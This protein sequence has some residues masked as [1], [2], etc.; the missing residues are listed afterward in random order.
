MAGVSV[1][2]LRIVFLI[3]CFFAFSSFTQAHPFSASRLP[4][5]DLSHLVQTTNLAPPINSSNFPRSETCGFEGNPDV[6]GP[7]IRIG[8]YTQTIAVWI[9]KYFLLSQAHVLR[10]SITIFSIALLSV[11]IIFAVR[12]PTVYTVE[13]FIVLQ[14]LSWS[15]LTG[16]R[17]RSSYA[18]QTFRN[19]SV[20]VGLTEMFNMGALILHTWFWFYG[21]DK[22]RM[23][24]CGAFVFFFAKV[25]MYGWFRG[26]MKAMT[27][28]GLLDHVHDVVLRGVGM[29]SDW[30]MRKWEEELEN[31]MKRWE[32]GE[33]E[34]NSINSGA[35]TSDDTFRSPVSPSVQ[36]STKE[37]SFDSSR[38]STWDANSTQADTESI[39]QKIH[40]IQASIVERQLQESLA[41]C[42]PPVTSGRLDTTQQTP[43][44]DSLETQFP[45]F[46]DI[47][48]GE[49]F[50]SHC[51]AARLSPRFQ[52]RHPIVY[53]ILLALLF[54]PRPLSSSDNRTSSTTS[55]TYMPSNSTLPS[56]H[57]PPTPK[58]PISPTAETGSE[59]AQPPTYTTCVIT[60]LQSIFTLNFPHRAAILL[61]HLIRSRSLDP[62]NGVYQLYAAL[63]SS[64]SSPSQST[65]PSPAGIALASSLLLSR[66]PDL[67]QRVKYMQ[68]FIDITIHIFMIL[69]LEFTIVWNGVRGLGG[70]ENVGQLI[71]F[72]IGVGGLGLVLGRWGEY[73][74]GCLRGKR[75]WR[76]MVEE[77]KAERQDDDLVE[78]IGKVYEEW[79]KRIAEEGRSRT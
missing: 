18:R 6:Y 60:I 33:K 4:S 21:M 44:T 12:A 8:I 62:I 51:I 64:P 29:W 43:H 59:P 11:S 5:P 32:E 74:W 10:D 27:L 63:T 53:K 17:S 30:P 41:L 26:L 77:V 13:F 71:P 1:V 19:R 61:I 3:S 54:V 20:R 22:T 69:Q 38:S 42:P 2:L 46:E 79:K 14:I 45:T 76:T 48:R 37:P 7:G 67:T 49:V 15:C 66:L 28:L 9:T 36:P 73:G 31:E 58:T 40:R 50:L 70:L 55:S 47:Y 75:E 39:S 52:E 65:I 35:S 72:I 57:P 68:T 16:V 23:V 34:S 25:D 78:G 24:G 56:T